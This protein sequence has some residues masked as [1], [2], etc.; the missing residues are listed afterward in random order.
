MITG[1]GGNIY[2]TARQF[3]CSPYEIIDMSSNVNPI[4][5]PKGLIHFLKENI[6]SITVLP[7]VD[8]Q[9][10]THAFAGQHDIDPE[11]I[12]AGNGTTQFIYTIPKALETQK[13]LI[14]GPAYADY[15]DACI[16]HGIDHEYAM[17]EESKEFKPDINQINKILTPYD[18]VFI[19][20]PNNP[21]GAMIPLVELEALCRSHPNIYFVVDES[22][23]PFVISG[24]KISMIQTSLPNV[25]VLISMSKIFRVPGLRLGFMVS[26]KKI[27]KKLTRYSLPWNVNSLAQAAALYLTDKTNKA[28]SFTEETAAFIET[29]RTKLAK[30][31]EKSSVIKLFPSSTLFVLAKL[32]N[33]YSAE[34][35]CTH[36][37]QNR[38]LIRNCANFE[39]LSDQFIRFSL[40]TP[41]INAM[42][43]NK[44]L[45][46]K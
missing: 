2:K 43:A 3:G 41:P 1:H 46:L 45:E 40:K 33:N 19:C 4:G 21:T 11:L 29:E 18:T 27:I 9:K 35:V 8:S 7:E 44:L 10:I 34:H 32:K 26:S 14:L 31:L 36:L 38:I 37:A 16:M 25:I 22:Y 5:P 20:N 30:M 17:A 13:T 6:N 15:A 24:N 12:V 23:L 39:G 28:N 42:L